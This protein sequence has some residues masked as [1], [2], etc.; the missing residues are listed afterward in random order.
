MIDNVSLQNVLTIVR[1][2]DTTMKQVSST[3]KAAP[4]ADKLELSGVGVDLL[5]PI[6]VT[7]I[8]QQKIAELRQ[9]VSS[10]NYKIC[11]YELADAILKENC[12]KI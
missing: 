1:Q 4:Q 2:G 9:A 5:K 7:R 12:I 11:Y 6:S 3:Q 8:S 10:G